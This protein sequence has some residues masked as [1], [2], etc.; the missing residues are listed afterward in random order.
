MRPL[1]LTGS[2]F[3][4]RSRAARC[5]FV[6]RLPHGCVRRVG[7]SC[8]V[9]QRMPRLASQCCPRGITL[10]VFDPGNSNGACSLAPNPADST[11]TITRS[12]TRYNCRL[13]AVVNFCLIFRRV[14]ATE[15]ATAIPS[16]STIQPCDDNLN[17]A[18]A[19][20]Y[21]RKYVVRFFLPTED[22]HSCVSREV[23]FAPNKE[24]PPPLDSTPIC[25]GRSTNSLPPFLTAQVVVVDLLSPFTSEHPWHDTRA[26]PGLLVD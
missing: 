4:E 15:R 2:R 14:Q 26:L 19:C 13:S 20:E 23:V 16:H 6:P 21:F 22:V 11:I 25:P 8:I 7:C 24:H 3:K 12:V 5:S 18:K 10:G 1:N 17:R 9:I